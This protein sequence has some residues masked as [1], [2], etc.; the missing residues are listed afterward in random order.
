MIIKWAPTS[1]Y[2]ALFVGVFEICLCSTWYM[3]RKHEHNKKIFTKS[4]FSKLILKP[5]CSDFRKN[6]NG[7]IFIRKTLGGSGLKIEM[8][9]NF[10]LVL[11]MEEKS[12]ISRKCRC[13]SII[14]NGAIRCNF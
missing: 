9:V 8:C 5:I 6:D 11:A 4:A 7:K 14:S 1:C 10:P 13:N 3:E 12:S 2:L